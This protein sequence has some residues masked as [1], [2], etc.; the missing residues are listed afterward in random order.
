[1]AVDAT[2]EAL[3]SIA[4]NG[5]DMTRPLE[6]DFFVAVPDEASGDAVAR[7]ARPSYDVVVAIEREL[8]EIGRRVGGYADGFGTFGNGGGN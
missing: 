4:S 3:E 1:M 6:M 7:R 2:K 8:D 5:S